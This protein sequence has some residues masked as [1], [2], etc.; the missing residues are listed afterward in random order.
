MPSF[1]LNPDPTFTM[2]SLPKS[3]TVVWTI[4]PKGEL[5]P[6]VVLGERDSLVEII[7]YPGEIDKEQRTV[8]LPGSLFATD[9][10]AIK[11]FKEKDEWII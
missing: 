1:L 9:E 6:C 7:M 2:E 3:N 4:S 10:E 8:C 11:L 5:S